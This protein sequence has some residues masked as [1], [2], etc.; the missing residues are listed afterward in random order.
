MHAEALTLSPDHDL[1]HSSQMGM[2]TWDQD[3]PKDQ[4]IDQG[5]HVDG[6]V[7]KTEIEVLMVV[8]LLH[9]RRQSSD[10]PNVP[11]VVDQLVN[12]LP[13]A[14]GDGPA[15]AKYQH[16]QYPSSLTIRFGRT[17]KSQDVVHVKQQEAGSGELEEQEQGAVFIF[18]VGLGDKKHPQQNREVGHDEASDVCQEILAEPW[19]RRVAGT[20]KDR[21][22]MVNIGPLQDDA[23]YTLT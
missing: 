19:P 11:M 22:A 7:K 2:A 21:L 3:S 10:N 9:R 6:G 23:K 12:V 14:M 17:H 4:R 15:L 1:V 13:V 8:G 16:A 20:E 18:A 5:E